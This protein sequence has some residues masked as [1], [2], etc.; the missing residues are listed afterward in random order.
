MKLVIILGPP[1]VGKMTVGQALADITGMKL[2]H[3]HMTSELV[4][5]FV[6]VWGEGS[7]E[8]RRLKDLFTREILEV[9]ARSDLPGMIFTNM[10]NFN[11]PKACAYI[12]DIIDLYQSHGA[13]TCVVELSADLDVRIER[14]KSENRLL[15][16][17]KKRDIAVSESNL[18]RAEAAQ[19][20][21][22]R[23]GETPFANYLKINNTHLSP[24]EVAV[25]I[26]E[27]LG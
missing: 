3:N 20:L 9:V 15:H 12:Q 16:K 27:A 14:N 8:G 4:R 18:R 19:N 25:I 5:Q 2:L 22:T 13:K 11:L 7:E 23:E 17:P 6:P 26:K 1:A 21:N 24:Q 10:L